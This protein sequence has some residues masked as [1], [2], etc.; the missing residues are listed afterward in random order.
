MLMGITPP[1]GVAVG[2]GKLKNLPCDLFE[3]LKR[4][5]LWLMKGITL[6]LIVVSCNSGFHPWATLLMVVP[7]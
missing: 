5:S 7:S 6:S 1:G 4:K 3:A 2:Q